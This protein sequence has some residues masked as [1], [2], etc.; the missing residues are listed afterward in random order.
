MV[1]WFDQLQCLDSCSSCSCQANHLDRA[2]LHSQQIHIV[3]KVYKVYI[4]PVSGDL[5]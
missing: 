2:C 4:L 5:S 3:Y 1:R